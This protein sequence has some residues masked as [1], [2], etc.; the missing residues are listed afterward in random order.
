MTRNPTVT[1]A[2]ARIPRSGP[3]RRDLR[4][5]ADVVIAKLC[6]LLNGHR[7]GAIVGA[8]FILSME[9][10]GRLPRK[11][12]LMWIKPLLFCNG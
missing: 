8:L 11:N 4:D 1:L 10:A 6:P 7:L 5:E 2:L 3:L 9:Y 12:T